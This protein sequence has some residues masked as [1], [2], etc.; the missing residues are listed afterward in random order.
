M[1]GDILEA[2]M[3]AHIVQADAFV[4]EPQAPVDD[5]GMGEPFH[6]AGPLFPEDPIPAVPLQEIPPPEAEEDM[7]ADDFDPVDLLAVPED[8][9]EDPPVID[10]P[11]DDEE[12]EEPEE[13]YG[14]DIEPEVEHAGWLDEADDQADGPEIGRAHV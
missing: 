3:V 1:I 6:E 11:D 4:D 12:D 2:E 9:R 8:P 14:E 5:A 13:E 10:I 7:A